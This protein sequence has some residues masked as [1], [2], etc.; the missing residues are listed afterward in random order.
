MSQT[1][2]DQWAQQVTQRLHDLEQGRA[3][4][5]WV[6]ALE[7]AISTIDKARLR[8]VI[9]ALKMEIMVKAAEK[10]H[11]RTWQLKRGLGPHLWRSSDAAFLELVAEGKLT[12]NKGGW[13]TAEEKK[14]IGERR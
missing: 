9:E 3:L 5:R 2:W 14:Q 12:K 6:E 1:T 11:W 4:S 13:I 10:K 7:Q 8:G